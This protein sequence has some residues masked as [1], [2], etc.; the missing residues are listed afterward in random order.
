MSVK[1]QPIRKIVAR[2]EF[3]QIRRQAIHFSRI[4]FIYREIRCITWCYAF[5]KKKSSAA[6]GGKSFVSGAVRLARRRSTAR[7]RPR[8]AIRQRSRDRQFVLFPAQRPPR[9]PRRRGIDRDRRVASY[10]GER[11]SE[12]RR[13]PGVGRPVQGSSSHIGDR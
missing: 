12:E 2:G 11:A 5:R 6:F 10:C 9:K 8:R 3:N 13:Y 7:G 4:T 1:R